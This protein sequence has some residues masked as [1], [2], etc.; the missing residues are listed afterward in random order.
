MN[1]KI[2]VIEDEQDILEL[3]GINLKKS[4]FIPYLFNKGEDI[5]KF[6]DNEDFDLIILDLMLPDI[7]G[8]EILKNIKE[9]KLKIP[10]IILTAKGDEAD[11]VIGLEVGADDYIVKP[12]SVRELIARI[13]VVLR[14]TKGNEEIEKDIIKINE[15]FVIY[16]KR[17][18]VYI[19]KEIINLT[20]TEFKILL[21]LIKRRGEV[22]SREEILD[23][24]WG[25]DKVV[26][27]RTVDVHIKNLR[28]KLGEFKNYIKSIRGVGYK[29]EI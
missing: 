5:L 10:V 14:R 27:D 7:D 17:Y 8:L 13:R 16:P 3:I 20:S 6:I 1:E 4:G 12:F 9:R 22:L 15:N 26:I 21:I 18:E 25:I 2:A 29:F 28:G 11:R 24:L 19:N 23:A